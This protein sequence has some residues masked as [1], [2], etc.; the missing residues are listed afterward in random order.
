[1]NTVVFL[2]SVLV[3]L[4][5]IVVVGIFIFESAKQYLLIEKSIMTKETTVF[6]IIAVILRVLVWA[7][8]RE[9]RGSVFLLTSVEMF[10]WGLMSIVALILPIFL[11]KI[12]NEYRSQI[13]R[14]AFSSLIKGTVL[15]FVLWLFY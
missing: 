9:L 8:D 5:S 2:F 12:E 13:R 14:T 11:K 15:A 1:M 4:V 10:L 3:G 6:Y 7:L